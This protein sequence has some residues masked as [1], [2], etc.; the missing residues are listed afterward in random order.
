MEETFISSGKVNQTQRLLIQKIMIS[1]TKAVDLHILP[2]PLDKK[3]DP[4]F[5]NLV[6][7]QLTYPSCD[8]LEQKV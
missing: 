6:V 7:M 3:E 4:F 8:S 2:N 1:F 5:S